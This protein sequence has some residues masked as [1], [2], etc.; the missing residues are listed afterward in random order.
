MTCLWVLYKNPPADAFARAEVSGV[1]ASDAFGAVIVRKRKSWRM[2]RGGAR[3]HHGARANVDVSEKC[4][5][6]GH[7]ASGTEMLAEPSISVARCGLWYWGACVGGA[8]V[9]ASRLGEALCADPGLTPP[10]LERA[11]LRASGCEDAEE[12]N[13]EVSGGR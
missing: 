10:G 2:P 9:A 6:I 4:E 7:R 3:F 8:C 1:H 12:E 11:A 5:G 13:W